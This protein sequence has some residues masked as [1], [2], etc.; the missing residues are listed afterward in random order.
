MLSANAAG[1]NANHRS[2]PGRPAVAARSAAEPGRTGLGQYLMIA[3][4]AVTGSFASIALFI[5]I[6]GW[7]D[8]LADLRFTNMARSHLQTMNAVLDDATGLLFS[9]RAYF[10]SLDHPVSRT[11]YQT[12]SHSLRQRVVGLHDTGWAPRVTAAERPGFER[13]IRATGHPD[14]EIR[15]RSADGRLV[16]AADRDEYFPILYSDPGAINRPILGFD[17][18]SEPMRN[19]VIARARATDRP[20]ATPPLKLMNMQQP[21]GGVMSFIAVRNAASPDAPATV[22]PKVA[23]VVLGAFETEPMI[24]NIL[25][26]KLP[27]DTLEM[28]LFDPKG[29]PGNRL[30]YWHSPT[31]RPAPAEAALLAGRHWAS[32]LELVD[33]QWGH[34]LRAVGELRRRRAELDGLGGARRRPHPDRIDRRLSLAHA[35][36]HPAAGT[37]DCQPARNRRGTASPRRQTGLSRPARHP[38]RAAQPPGVS[39]HRRKR[40]EAGAPRIRSGPAL[41]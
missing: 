13:A 30:I 19:R 29:S 2:D 27:M 9:M 11:E 7:Q 21:N 4:T 18:A 16:R 20:A 38:D 14:F 15:E 1:L 17:L 26:S 25:A 5:A 34:R 22:S 10:E 41:P 24:A 36:P 12:F 28:Y 40:A 8:H 35:A 37:A 23:G 39:R 6:T 3:L 33:Q 32:T 31:T